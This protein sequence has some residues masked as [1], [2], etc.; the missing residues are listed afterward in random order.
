M[1]N[2][3]TQKNSLSNLF[4]KRRI[5]GSYEAENR[6]L[7][8]KLD[9]LIKK[10]NTI[11]VELAEKDNHILKLKDDI[12]IL[13]EKGQ[14]QEEL[15]MARDEFI[16]VNREYERRSKVFEDLSAQKTTERMNFED[17][18]ERLSIKEEIF[19]RC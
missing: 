2:L 13:R 3:R 16:E 19:S 10:T 6:N 4:L 15:K 1:L 11:K 14:C 17:W 5:V 18:R 9:R 12:E 8:S 7:E